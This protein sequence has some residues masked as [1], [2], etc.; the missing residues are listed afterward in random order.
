MNRFVRC[1]RMVPAH[2]AVLGY[3]ASFGTPALSRRDASM[4]SA[5]ASS[6]A[7]EKILLQ[8]LLERA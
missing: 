6:V 7:I 1:Q 2:D 4:R 5:T 8:S 3:P